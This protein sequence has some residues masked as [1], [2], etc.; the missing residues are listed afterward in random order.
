MNKLCPTILLMGLS[1]SLLAQ[2]NNTPSVEKSI[3]GI[4]TGFMGLWGYN[5]S[6]LSNTIALRS[7]LGFD[8]GFW[9]GIVYEKTGFILAPVIT[10]EP[11]LYYNL[12]KRTAKSRSIDNNS[13]NFVALKLRYHPDWFAISNYEGVSVV[14]DISIIPTWGIRR[15]IGKH[16][17]YEVGAGLA[18]RYFFAKSA[19][20]SKNESNAALDLTARIGYTF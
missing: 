11:R 3:F 20:Y 5:E 6:G 8:G 13:S 16:F 7:E 18:Y 4:Q 1:L 2:K 14:S 10:A 19:G 12:K 9:G 15:R 17:N